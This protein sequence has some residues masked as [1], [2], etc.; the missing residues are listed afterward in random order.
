MSEVQI[1]LVVFEIH[2]RAVSYLYS[3]LL[4]FGFAWFVNKVLGKKIDDISMTESLKSVD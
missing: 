4:T 1:D 3:G 2:V